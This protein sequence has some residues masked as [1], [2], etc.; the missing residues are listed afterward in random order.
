MKREKI[1]MI[2]ALLSIFVL[3]S[4]LYNFVLFD[5][6]QNT[7]DKYSTS[8]EQKKILETYQRLVSGDKYELHNPLYEE[9]T[10]F[11]ENDTSEYVNQTLA[12]AKSMGLRCALVN[13]L[14]AYD[15][16]MY[17]ILGFETVNKGMVYFEHDTNYRVFPRIGEYYEKCAFN[18]EGEN[19]YHNEY[20]DRIIDIVIIW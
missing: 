1:K 7:Y 20:N 14:I 16:Q 19:P 11:I 5:E 6:L 17:Q 2:I 8:K 9:V 13:I 3:L 18:D 4:I 12:N 10:T 15:K